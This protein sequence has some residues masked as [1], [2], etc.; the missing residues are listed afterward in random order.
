MGKK[1][2]VIGGL[3]LFLAIGSLGW[4][5]FMN[6]ATYYYEVNDFLERQELLGDQSVRVN[7][8]V[9]SGSVETANGG[10]GITF[11]IR[12]VTLSSATIPVVYHGAVPDTF[13]PDTDVV[14]EGKFSAD[15]VFEATAIMTKCAS[16]YEPEL[17][18]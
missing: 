10:L 9:V 16:K 2:F 13:Q 18:E 17:A 12:D 3:I 8:T 1:K 14:V 6:S 11:T 7:G 5:G 4:V 15:G